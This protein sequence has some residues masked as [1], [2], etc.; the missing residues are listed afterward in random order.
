VKGEGDE[1]VHNKLQEL[2]KRNTGFSTF[3]SVCQVLNGDDIDPPLKTFA[4]E[5]ISMLK[6]APVTSCDA[7]KR[8]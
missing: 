8:F 5:K 4:P 1:N 7:K 3:T 2:L 6:Y